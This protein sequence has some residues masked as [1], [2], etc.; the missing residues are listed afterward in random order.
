MP[1]GKNWV[2]FIYINLAFALYIV[3]TYLVSSIQE[4]KE[5]WPMYRCNPMYMPLSDNVEQ[6]FV[7]CIQNIQTNS[8]GFLLQPMTFLTSSITS[9]LGEF[10]EEINYIREMFNKIRTMFTSIIQSVFG[11]FLNLIIEFQKIIIS[12]KDL[13]GKTI[14]TMVTFLFVMDGSLKTMNSAWSGPTGQ[15]VRSLGKCFHP[16]TKV[17]LQNGNV[18]SISDVNL[19]DI[20]ENGSV[21]ESTM[22]IN[23]M[24]KTERIY[25]INGPTEIYVTGSH[26]VFDKSK[27]KFIKVENYSNAKLVDIN[28]DWF[29]CLITSD[30]KIIIGD[31]IFWDWEDHFVHL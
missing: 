14:G 28:I 18:I 24:N 27:N 1:S 7:Y 2:N 12:M 31:E 20:L 4:I 21:V 29:S 19:G 26:L 6:D 30:H 15:L 16:D 13:V 25:L 10:V 11:V 17:K 23:N 22:K 5:N 8:M 3:G 9:V